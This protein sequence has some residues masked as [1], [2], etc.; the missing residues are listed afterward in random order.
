MYA[1]ADGSISC[2]SE[3]HA[4][5]S[6]LLAAVEFGSPSE[7]LHVDFVRPW[8]GVPNSC[9]LAA[10]AS[11]VEKRVASAASLPLCSLDL[12]VFLSDVTVSAVHALHVPANAIKH[13]APAWKIR[14]FHVGASKV[15]KYP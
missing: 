1:A 2:C 13:S 11:V 8:L 6:P 9:E 4:P 14:I 5:R 12:P 7:S 10:G 3:E 15:I